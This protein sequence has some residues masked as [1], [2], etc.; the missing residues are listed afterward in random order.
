[1][2]INAMTAMTDSKMQQELTLMNQ[3]HELDLHFFVILWYI[4]HLVFII[5]N[6]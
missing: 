6:C 3:T 2:G 1:M 5:F 4:N